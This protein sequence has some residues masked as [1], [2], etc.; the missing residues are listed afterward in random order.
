MRGRPELLSELKKCKS[1]A[2]RKRQAKSSKQRTLPAPSSAVTTRE[3]LPAPSTAL[4]SYDTRAVSPS[5]STEDGFVGMK[6]S[7]IYDPER[8]ARSQFGLNPAII[9]TQ[10][11]GRIQVQSPNMQVSSFPTSIKAT[12]TSNPSSPTGKFD[13]LALAINCLEKTNAETSF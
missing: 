7:D 4:S 13:L 6:F 1:A 3:I 9:P 12:R 5:S 11:N 8:R 2:D 10:L